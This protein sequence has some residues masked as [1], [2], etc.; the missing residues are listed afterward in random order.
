MAFLVKALF[1][2]N[3]SSKNGDISILSNFLAIF[4]DFSPYREILPCTIYMSNFRLI[5]PPKQKLPSVIPICIKTG[6]FRV[7]PSK[8]KETMKTFHCFSFR[9]I[10]MTIMTSYY[11]I[12]NDVINFFQK[13]HKISTHRIF[14]RSFSII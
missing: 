3:K 1:R 9:N 10:K 14:L 7:N 2:W 4:S 5:G 6:L 11:L 13:F 8:N 12:R